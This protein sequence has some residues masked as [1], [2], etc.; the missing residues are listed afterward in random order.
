MSVREL[1]SL[2]NVLSLKQREYLDIL[3]HVNVDNPSAALL[4]QSLRPNEQVEG[5]TMAVTSMPSWSVARPNISGSPI[6]CSLVRLRRR[7]SRNGL[8]DLPNLPFGGGRNVA[9]K[10]LTESTDE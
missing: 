1:R 10:T 8:G 5:N 9:G 7:I 2:L 3:V 6:A 4:Q